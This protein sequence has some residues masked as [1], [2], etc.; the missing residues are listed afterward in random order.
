MQ[1]LA[2][3]VTNGMMLGGIYALTALGLT[4]VY[5]VLRFLNLAH[6]ELVMAGA[7]VGLGIA[8]LTGNVFLTLVGGALAVALL[9]VVLERTTFRFVRDKSHLVPLMMSV[10]M[11]SV[12][13]EVG[14]LLT[15]PGRPRPYPASVQSDSTF[16]IGP[17]TVSPVQIL[18][19]LAAA[20]LMVLLHLVMTRSKTGLALRAMSED[21]RIA[22]LLGVDADRMASAAFFIVGLLSGVAGVCYGLI[23]STVD[24]YIG[25]PLG[26]KA[27]VVVIFAGLGNMY[28][29]MFGGLLLGLIEVLSNAYL[30]PGWGEMF[31]FLFV[32]VVLI[33][34]PSGIFGTPYA[35]AR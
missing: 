4:L 19:L 15:S 8:T 1:A 16:L 32:V 2:Q 18:T 13:T 9:A 22:R 23:Y 17:V 12:L 25:G 7:L 21:L 26:I 28:G 33:V 29:A 11:V 24:P 3:Q 20:L 6:G 34:R 35:L 27:V 10:G 30:A 31:S 5:A 14:R